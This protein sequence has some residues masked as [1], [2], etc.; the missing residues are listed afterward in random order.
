MKLNKEN[1]NTFS[2]IQQIRFHLV[3]LEKSI[4]EIFKLFEKR[5]R[6]QYHRNKDYGERGFFLNML[7]DE[8]NLDA[9]SDENI[10]KIK[11]LLVEYQKLR[12]EQKKLEDKLLEKE[13]IAK[14]N[15]NDTKGFI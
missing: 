2:K 8:I 5:Q 11:N 7:F 15:V 6:V 10:S 4:E 12:D 14:M 3:D 13:V 1:V 9:F